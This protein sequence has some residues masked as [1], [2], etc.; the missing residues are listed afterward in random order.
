[1]IRPKAQL[2]LKNAREYFREHLQVGDYYAEDRT[3]MGERIGQGALSLGMSGKVEEKAFL[4]LCSG[5]DPTTGK[6]LTQRMNSTRREEGKDEPN[7][8]I[9]YDFVISPPKSISVVALYQ[10][11]R[12]VEL[13]NRAVRVAMTELETYAETRVRTAKQN[14]ERVT[15]N[16]VAACFRHDTSREL[17]PHLHTHCVVF[18]ATFDPVE[19]RWKALHASGM[20]RAQKFAENLYFHEMGKGL[21]AIGYEIENNSRNF[22]IRGVPKTVI[23]RFSKRHRQIDEETRR[24]IEKDGEPSNVARLRER[25][26]QEKRRRK[27]KDSTAGRLRAS[28]GEELSPDERATLA[29]VRV[30]PPGYPVKADVPEIVTWADQHLFERRAVV[31]DHELMSAALARGRGQDFDL[32][33]LRAEIDRRGYFQEEGTRRLTSRQTL[34]WEIAVVRAAHDGQWQLDPLNASYVPP[35]GLSS[36]QREAVDQI[37]KSEDFITLFQGA[38]GTGKSRTL[39]AVVD[40]LKAAGR[41]VVVLTPQRQQAG[42]LEADGLAATTLARCLQARDL[43][44]RPVVLLD[45]A[46]Q[47]GARQMSELVGLVQKYGGRLV[48][49]GDTRQHGAV[50]ASD[51]LRAI[52]KH[53]GLKPAVLREIRRQDPDRAKSVGER[54]FIADYRRAVKAASDGRIEESFDRLDRMGC[55]RETAA[56]ERP[57]LLA[58]EYLASV[59]RGEK[60]LVVAQTWDEVNRAN[61]AIREALRSQGKI[62]EGVALKILQTVDLSEAQK[63]DARFIPAGAHAVFRKGYGRFKRGDACSIVEANDRGLVLLKNGRRSTLSYR[64]A[65]RVSIATESEMEVA[66]GDRLQLKFNGRTQDGQRIANGELVTVRQ[67]NGD[68]SLE[69]ETDT[70][71]AKTLAPDQRLFRRGYAVTSYASQG[72]TVDTVLVADS[73]CRAATNGNQ[74]Y[75]AISRGRKRVTVFTESKAELRANIAR[76]G[77]RA[78]AMDLNA[79]TETPVAREAVEGSIRIGD[80]TSHFER[81]R[82]QRYFLQI[83]AQNSQRQRITI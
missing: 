27:Q 66:A 75:V 35:A 50:E 15:G 10:D 44:A 3:I 53:A 22:E 52:E 83:T 46:G 63:R 72:K 59:G 37:L 48:L 65:D 16:V 40:G 61:E 41:P 11:Q 54:A 64:R 6:R 13:H 30:R 45:E 25:V 17:D 81:L 49:S 80:A 18:N 20:Y 31:Q 76:S 73:A 19:K 58:G 51:V 5:I 77:D 43:P 36:E 4:D 74:W 33:K 12:I 7:R 57:A 39:R 8:R 55:I 71:T 47:V 24:R 60:T 56:A 26:A 67:V 38:A 29:R 23:D 82:R 68:G 69:V 14:S 9:F 28:W 62:G 2:S 34:K 78:L 32:A 70:G 1:M 21:R 79:S 42:D